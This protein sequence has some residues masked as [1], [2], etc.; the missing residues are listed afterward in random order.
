MKDILYFIVNKKMP[1][2]RGHLGMSAKFEFRH[3]CTSI[4]FVKTAAVD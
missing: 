2:I 3:P 4:F 1:L